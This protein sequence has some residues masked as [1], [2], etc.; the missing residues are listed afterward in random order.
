MKPTLLEKDGY[1]H[2]VQHGTVLAKNVLKV[3]D[4]KEA[5]PEEKVSVEKFINKLK[6]YEEFKLEFKD[7]KRQISGY[8]NVCLYLDWNFIKRN[9]IFNSVQIAYVNSDYDIFIEVDNKEVCKFLKQCLTSEVIFNNL[10][11][12]YFFSLPC[13]K[14]HVKKM[15]AFTKELD[16]E[17]K[18]MTP[19]MLVELD[20]RLD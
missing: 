10:P 7:K 16:K 8:L 6:Q 3:E 12:E 20:K 5:S 17:F 18:L 2:I 11:D 9:V 4:I 13:F 14:E 1:Y 15:K 19:P